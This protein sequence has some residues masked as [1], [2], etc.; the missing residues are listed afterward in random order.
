MMDYY[1]AKDIAGYLRRMRKHDVRYFRIQGRT[2]T[3]ERFS[4]WPFAGIYLVWI[5][6]N[7]VICRSP[8]QIAQVI[9]HT[10]DLIFLNN[11][12]DS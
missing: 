9:S 2:V 11:L 12:L 6:G 7:Y 5:R 1:H 10:T 8:L 4:H 3:V